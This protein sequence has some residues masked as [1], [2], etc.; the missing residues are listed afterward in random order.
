MEQQV[1]N[2]PIRTTSGAS[3]PRRFATAA[4][5][6]ASTRAPAPRISRTRRSPFSAAQKTIGVSV[7]ISILSALCAHRTIFG[8]APGEEDS[9]PMNVARQLLEQCAQAIRGGETKIRGRKL[10]TLQNAGLATVALDNCPSRLCPTTF[11]A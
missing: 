2:P 5:Y 1:N 3:S 7:A 10:S 8:R 6:S 4:V 9:D 11:N